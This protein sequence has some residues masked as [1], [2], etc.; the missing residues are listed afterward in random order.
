MS[1]TVT[2]PRKKSRRRSAESRPTSVDPVTQYARDVVDGAIVAGRA[3]RLTC[4]RHLTDLTRQR[5]REFPYYFDTAAAQHIID[6]FPK[7]LTLENGDP[8][9]LPPWLQF[10]YGCIYGWK[11]WGGSRYVVLPP[12]QA[13]RAGLR[14]FVHG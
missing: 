1:A 12:E 13:Q 4:R 8:F 2:A 11:C 3:V 5:T 7:F 14:R 10:S 9:V 6:F